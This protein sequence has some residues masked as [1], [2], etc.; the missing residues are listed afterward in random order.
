MIDK[1][2]NSENPENRRERFAKK[3]SDWLSRRNR[4]EAGEATAHITF[5]DYVTPDGKDGEIMI[6][7]FFREK[8]VSRDEVLPSVN[9]IV[10]VTNRNE[11]VSIDAYYVLTKEPRA[12]GQLPELHVDEVVLARKEGT[13]AMPDSR[14]VLDL[15][16]KSFFDHAI[17][18][19]TD[20]T[21][22]PKPGSRIMRFIPRAPI[23]HPR[24]DDIEPDEMIHS[25][26]DRFE[27]QVARH[28]E[29][30]HE[31]DRVFDALAKK[32]S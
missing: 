1:D 19:A 5:F 2:I 6:S 9:E 21:I 12:E 11:A 26:L 3:I 29:T 30:M 4:E 13:I 23:E 16:P 28:G 20:E 15:D 31:L 24:A 7:T 27:T 18:D 22:T 8:P 10:I 17:A 14:V 32:K 25:V